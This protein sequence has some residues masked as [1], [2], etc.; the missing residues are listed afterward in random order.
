MIPR[1]EVA[2]IIAGIG[3]TAGILDEQMFGV[4]ILMTLVTTLFAP[5][6]ISASLSINGKGTKKETRS[7]DNVAFTWDFGSDEIA[8]LVIDIFLKDLRSEGFYVQMMNI[9]D[10]ISQA[11]KDGISLSITETESVVKIETSAEDSGFVKNAMYEV[12]IR[13]GNLVQDLKE[14]YVPEKINFFD[15]SEVSRTSSD[16]LKLFAPDA[17]SVDL[18]GT[19]KEQILQEMVMLLANSGAVR[20]WE[21]VLA[22]VRERENI[23]STGMQHGVAFPHG[24]SDAVTHTCVALGISRNGVD[25]DSLDGEKC[26]VFVMIVSP[27]KTSSPHMLLLSSMSYILR[28]EK[29][30]EELLKCPDAKSL[31]EK[32]KEFAARKNNS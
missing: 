9:S 11:R 26:K 29:N 32:M 23:M 22:D 28:D 25:F 4:V 3:L 5:P 1:G 13:L 24:K 7:T 15:Q 2:L 20:N 16:I 27:K 19:T 21:T 17:V 30:V 31:F 12:L 14:N 18:K 6:L 8:D 10:G